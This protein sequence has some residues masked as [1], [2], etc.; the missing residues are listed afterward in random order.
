LLVGVLN[1][2]QGILFI[3]EGADLVSR[4][5]QVR[6]ALP[7]VFVELREIL[8]DGC[9]AEAGI[10]PVLRGPIDDDVV[11]AWADWVMRWRSSGRSSARWPRSASNRRARGSRR[12]SGRYRL[13][14]RWK[15][16]PEY[17]GAA[18]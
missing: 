15:F 14:W 18:A 2:G 4:L 13:G 16:G 17:D 11:G 12:S 7:D 6:L 9:A 5:P 10:P 8:L 1:G 3:D